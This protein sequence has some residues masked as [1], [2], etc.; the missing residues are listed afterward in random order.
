MTSSYDKKKEKRIQ[1][2]DKQY[3]KAYNWALHD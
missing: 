1:K 2:Q 3:L